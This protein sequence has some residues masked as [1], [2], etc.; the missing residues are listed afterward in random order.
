MEVLH[1]DVILLSNSVIK[2]NLLENAAI[3]IGYLLHWNLVCHEGL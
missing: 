2:I 1:L 3:L